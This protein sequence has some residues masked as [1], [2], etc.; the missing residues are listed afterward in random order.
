MLPNILLFPVTLCAC[1]TLG[2]VMIPMN[3]SYR[4]EDADMC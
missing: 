1:Y 4:S 3:I 2:A